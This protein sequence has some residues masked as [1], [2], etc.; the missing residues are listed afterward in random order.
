LF[1]DLALLD[2]KIV[3]VDGK[4]SIAEAVAVKFGKILSVGL[5]EDVKSLVGPETEVIDLE[6]RTVIPGLIESHCHPTGAAQQRALTIDGSYDAGVRSI[7]DIQ[8]RIADDARR[9]PEGEW[10]NVVN[11]DD[12]K[13]AERRH[14]YRW[15]LDEVAPDNPVMVTTIGGHFAVVN[16]KAFEMAG[17]TKDSPDPMGGRFERDPETGELTGWIHE[18]A[19]YVLQ[20]IRYGRYPTLPEAI[21][22]IR[23]VLTQYASSGLTCASDGGIMQ[24]VLVRAL[25][26]LARRGEL[27]IRIRMDLRCEMMPDLA[28][29]GIGEG[30]GNDMLRINAIKI[31]ADGA[32]S[33]RTA[34][35]AD[36]YLHRP[37]YYGELAITREELHRIVM[38][39]Y[40]L[41][42]RFAVHANGERAINMFL[43]IIEEA[44]GRYPRGDPRNRCIHCTVVNPEI[45]ARIKRLG[46]LPTIF[47]P[48]PYYHG[49]KI[50]PAFGAERLER[51]FAARSFLDAGV[52]VAAHS[53]HHASPYPPLMGI[54]ALVNRKTMKGLPIGTSQ[55]ISVMEALKLYTIN[56]AHHLFEEDAMGSIERGK[57]ADMVILGEDILTVPTETI[58][59]IPIDMT[60]V[61]GRIVYN[62]ES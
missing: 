16:S 45:I 3:T 19:A 50:L 25:Q 15:E 24:S 52:K 20:P 23:W 59:N 58:V 32:I 39:G 60:M 55:R 6:G 27:P 1:A 5:D 8:A 49:D 9:K 22:S 51:M 38:E 48:Y 47:G 53:D 31:I 11:E 42:Y 44:Q 4:E 34:A 2:G 46:V 26:A 18:R 33:A 21:E 14:P 56:A 62:R 54:H 41:G 35:V 40:P 57:L 43:D 12:S 13:L 10:I 36:P 17:V 30:F 28:A 37:D 29:L 7:S 61:G